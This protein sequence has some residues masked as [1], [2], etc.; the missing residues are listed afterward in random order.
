[1]SFGSFCH[2]F[3]YSRTRHILEYAEH[4]IFEELGK[5]SPSCLIPGTET[6]APGVQEVDFSHSPT[7]ET[8]FFRPF[9][10]VGHN[11]A[12]GS[13][14]VLNLHPIHGGSKIPHCRKLRLSRGAARSNL[15]TS[16]LQALRSPPIDLHGSGVCQQGHHHRRIAEPSI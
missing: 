8:L 1:M 11:P 14:E 13:E 2:H 7:L 6:D 12:T 9:R 5:N 10:G 16:R 15:P 3:S 4:S